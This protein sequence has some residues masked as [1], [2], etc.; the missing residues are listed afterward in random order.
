[1]LWLDVDATLRRL[2]QNKK[3]INDFC[4][5]FHGGPGGE[6]DLKTYTFDDVVSALNSLAPYDWSGYLRER[7]D[8]T[9]AKTPVESVESSGWKL[10]YTEQPNDFQD[11]ADSVRKRLNLSL[12]IGIVV[13]R[14]G[15]IDD[16]IYDSVAYKAGLGPGMKITAVDGRQFTPE[17][18][19]D[20][21]N[22]AKSA[23]A[24]I[25][26]IVANGP[27]VQTYS[28]DY[29]GGLSYPHLEINNGAPDFLSD[30]LKPLAK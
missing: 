19:K 6:P 16:V 13:S 24:P 15:S 3:S 1:M 22:A 12:S 8:A 9:P 23:A 18:L 30:I 25:Q 7:L 28:I 27:Q 10:V 2:T 4:R 5:A 21:I 29:H 20:S 26:L 14:D 11:N 17:A